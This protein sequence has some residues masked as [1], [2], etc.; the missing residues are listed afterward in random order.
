MLV[1]GAANWVWLTGLTQ[2][3]DCV[4]TVIAVSSQYCHRG[5]HF[6]SKKPMKQHHAIILCCTRAQTA[7]MEALEAGT[8][9]LHHQ[10]PVLHSSVPVS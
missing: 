8:G 10:Q 9:I 7:L 2:H 3:P 4:H 6:L 1:F 5:Q